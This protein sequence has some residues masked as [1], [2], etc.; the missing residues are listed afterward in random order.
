MQDG[1]VPFGM[2]GLRQ[3]PG[4]VCPLEVLQARFSARLS[5]VQWLHSC[6][7][8]LHRIGAGNLWIRKEA[9]FP[10]SGDL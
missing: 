3:G 4:P 1:T 10:S 8:D 9:A 7:A 6:F 5:R 2:A